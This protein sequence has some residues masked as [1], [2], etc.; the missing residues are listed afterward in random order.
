[1][2]KSNLE[3]NTSYAGAETKRFEAS[4]SATPLD[5]YE[6]TKKMLQKTGVKFIS[7][8]KIQFDQSKTGQDYIN[9]GTFGSVYKCRK[10]G[11]KGKTMAVKIIYGSSISNWSQISNEL[12]LQNL[13]EDNP[14]VVRIFDFCCCR[15]S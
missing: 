11:Q 15:R 14:Y 1:M 8:K 2:S 10:R 5:K 9:A 4:F 3:K 7:R 6:D 13:V 12:L